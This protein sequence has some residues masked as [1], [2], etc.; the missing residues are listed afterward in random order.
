MDVQRML[1][2]YMYLYSETCC[3]RCVRASLNDWL[4]DWG[5]GAELWYRPH[6]MCKQSGVGLT[7]M[8]RTSVSCCPPLRCQLCQSCWLL[9]GASP[10]FM[11]K[12]GK[13]NQV[14]SRIQISKYVIFIHLSYVLR[15]RS[16]QH[17]TAK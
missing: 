14:Y 10:I 17:I 5:V 1:A 6:F 9:E 7:Y 12:R 3:A 11:R 15:P 2:S 16:A 4:P 8:Y 13:A